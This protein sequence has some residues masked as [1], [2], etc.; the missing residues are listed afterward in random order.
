[1]KKFDEI[2]QKGTDIELVD[3]DRVYDEAMRELPF[4][5]RKY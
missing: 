4:D 2:W 3:L 1:M 5:A